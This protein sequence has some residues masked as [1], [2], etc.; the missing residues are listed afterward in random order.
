MANLDFEASD[1]DFDEDEEYFVVT[2]PE[3]GEDDD[4]LVYPVLSAEEAAEI[5]ANLG[6]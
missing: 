1:S 2:V 4:E 5:V 6:K 3:D